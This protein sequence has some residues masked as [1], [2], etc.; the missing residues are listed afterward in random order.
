MS[1]SWWHPKLSMI[2][3]KNFADDAGKKERLLR[4]HAR[5][6]KVL[7]ASTIKGMLSIEAST[8]SA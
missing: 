1:N 3:E 6:P 4:R 2:Q 8:S 5:D 7:H